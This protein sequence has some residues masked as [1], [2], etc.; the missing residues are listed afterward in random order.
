[1]QI[2]PSFYRGDVLLLRRFFPETGD[3]PLQE[4]FRYGDVL[5][6]DV[7]SR[8]RFVRRRFVRRRFVCAPSKV[9]P[10]PK[11]RSLITDSFVKYKALLLPIQ[12]RI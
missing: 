1:M 9:L 5:Y 7:L 6:G 11:F 10:V 8:R 2:F 4:T 12:F 3:V